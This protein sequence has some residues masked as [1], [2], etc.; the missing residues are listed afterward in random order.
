LL[1]LW[2]ALLIS[3]QTWCGDPECPPRPMCSNAE[4]DI[5]LALDESCSMNSVDWNKEILF[6][7]SLATAAEKAF[8]V[9]RFSALRFGY[10]LSSYNCPV[11]QS[12]QLFYSMAPGAAAFAA[13]MPTTFNCGGTPT[14]EA[15]SLFFSELNRTR[16]PGR[17]QLAILVT[18]G[19][20][21]LCYTAGGNCDGTL[22]AASTATNA[23]IAERFSPA[24]LPALGSLFMTVGIGAA[25]SSTIPSTTKYGPITGATL[26][27]D[28][29]SAPQMAFLPSD[30][31]VLVNQTLASAIDVLCFYVISVVSPARATCYTG[32]TTFIIK[33]YNFF[34]TQG[35]PMC[36]W[37]QVGT[38]N[39]L[40][41]NAVIN[42]TN[43][44]FQNLPGV[45]GLVSCPAPVVTTDLFNAYLEISRDGTYF[46]NNQYSVLLRINCNA[47]IPPPPCPNATIAT[48]FSTCN[49]TDFASGCSQACLIASNALGYAFQAAGIYPDFTSAQIAAC[50]QGYP[51]TQLT[52]SEKSLI[53]SL[54]SPG[55]GP[56][57]PR[58]TT[59][60]AGSAAMSLICLVCVFLSV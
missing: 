50:I 15:I 21:T 29:S 11:P 36:R 42:V 25:V 60:G 37:Q 28:F 4:V 18:D 7:T 58:A 23:A 35:Q 12:S 33:G 45:V 5:I 17:L 59:S 48:L 16:V 46:T 44:V 3:A 26:L 40:Y 2:Q 56:C 54:S 13:A 30:F 57:T 1:V 53:S 20:P 32:G 6:S 14:D 49:S 10:G 27:K 51:S 19:I 31:N 41:T 47:P 55:Q 24:K 39:F 43:T 22:N 9:S 52:S 8:N 34:P 38:Q